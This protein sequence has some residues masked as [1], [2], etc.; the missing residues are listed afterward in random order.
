MKNLLFLMTNISK[1]FGGAFSP[2]ETN[3]I[4][5]WRIKNVI[6]IPLLRNHHLCHPQQHEYSL[7][8]QS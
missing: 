1:S 3:Y 5:S 8:R 6:V 4:K 7:H 2:A